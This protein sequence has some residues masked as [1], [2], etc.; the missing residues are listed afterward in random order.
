[1]STDRLCRGRRHTAA[2]LV[3]VT[4]WLFLV[5][6]T[7]E[8]ATPIVP[9]DADGVGTPHLLEPTAEMRELAEQQCLDDPTLDVGEINA[10]DPADDDVILAT[11]EVDCDTV[12]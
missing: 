11:V 2:A 9:G 4:A 12:R 1:V 7:G 8:D 10:V 5:G 6:C 3:L